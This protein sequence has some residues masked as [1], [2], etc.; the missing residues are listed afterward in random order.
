[1]PESPDAVTPLELGGALEIA[2]PPVMPPS[3]LPAEGAVED[4]VPLLVSE[5]AVEDLE[6]LLVSEGAGVDCPAASVV[7]AWDFELGFVSLID[8]VSCPW[9]FC[10]ILIFTSV[11]AGRLPKFKVILSFDCPDPVVISTGGKKLDA[12]VLAG[13]KD[14]GALAEYPSAA[15]L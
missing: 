6:P 4:L 13:S 5:G 7:F 15:T 14:V 1:M 12:L 11:P 2:P 9:A 10:E 8:I 3:E